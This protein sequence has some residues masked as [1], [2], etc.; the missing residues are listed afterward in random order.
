MSAQ[1]H[2]HTANSLS[3]RALLCVALLRPPVLSLSCVCA[4]HVRPPLAL[5]RVAFSNNKRHTH[6]H[7]HALPF[8]LPWGDPTTT[9]GSP[10]LLLGLR[11]RCS[12]AATLGRGHPKTLTARK[13]LAHTLQKLGEVRRAEEE[14]QAVIEAMIVQL[15]S[16]H[17]DT[18]S[19]MC[20]LGA[21]LAADCLPRPLGFVFPSFSCCQNC[22]CRR[23]CRC[24]CACVRAR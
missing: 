12:R 5:P 13:N 22:C 11:C 8:F 9:T 19:S 10:R 18:L 14:Y 4:P 24:V 2:A 15:G 1:P 3:R 20:N 17:A 16:D 23:C 21:L 6:T 7:T